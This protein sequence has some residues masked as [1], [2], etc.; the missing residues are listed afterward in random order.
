[1]K[2]LVLIFSLMLPAWLY[3]CTGT[4]PP[5][6]TPAEVIQEAHE[7]IR[8][9]P[10]IPVPPVDYSVPKPPAAKPKVKAHGPSRTP[11]PV[12]R[13]LPPVDQVEEPFVP[14]CLFWIIGEWGC[15]PQ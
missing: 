7:A 13:P 12:P 5:I 6:P 14:K 11:R 3:S 9:I 4:K 2:K 8:E 10:I 15:E 1:M